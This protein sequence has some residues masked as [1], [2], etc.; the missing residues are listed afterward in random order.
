MA[1]TS[2]K[3]EDLKGHLLSLEAEMKTREDDME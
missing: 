2:M 3:I 1:T